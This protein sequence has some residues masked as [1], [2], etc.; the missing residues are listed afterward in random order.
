[1]FGSPGLPKA[2]GKTGFTLVELLVVIAIIGILVALLLPA[3]QAAR[4]AARRS[5]CSNKLK[6]FGLA[7]HNYH[8]TVRTL[9]SGVAASGV[10]KC[11]N[12]G[13]GQGNARA[14]W[15]VMI[16]PY[17]EQAP[18]YDKF[19]QTENFSMNW[20]QVG[21]SNNHALATLP[22]PAFHCPSDPY[23]QESASNYMACAGGGPPSGFASSDAC[24]ATSTANFI[25]YYNGAI[26][27]N[28]KTNLSALTDGTSN[29]YLMGES[30]YMVNRA[31]PNPAKAGCWACSTY[32]NASWRY[33]VNITAA[34]EPINQ[35]PA[36]WYTKGQPPCNESLPGRVFGSMHPGGCQTLFADGSVQF[37]T[38]TLDVNIHRSLGARADGGPVGGYQ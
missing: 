33:Y 19:I 9:P 27:V 30:K 21:S 24:A 29:T 18:L 38:Q 20:E 12:A 14:T 5:E 32:L 16:L 34:V 1:M 26:Y 11:A 6:Q 15:S 13:S 3:V 17:L 22:N 35:P 25:L 36:G 28:S 10:D 23:G 37:M 7:M 4:E 31:C 2:R 8:D